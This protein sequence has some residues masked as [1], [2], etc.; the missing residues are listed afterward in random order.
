MPTNGMEEKQMIQVVESVS[1]LREK[2]KP[3][4]VDLYFRYFENFIKWL[5]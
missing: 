4:V 1:R 2:V 3:V 5:D